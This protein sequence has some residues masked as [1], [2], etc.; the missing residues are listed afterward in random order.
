MSPG[1][2]K[3]RRN[4][5][6]GA[7]AGRPRR[8]ANGLPAAPGRLA[9]I[10]IGS[11]SIHMVVVERGGPGASSGYR[12]LARERDMVRLGKSALSEGA[13]SAR[14]MR[15]GL[16]AL[17]KMTTLAR[18]K[19]AGEI[20]A[21]ATSAVR[22]A[23][24]G[25]EFLAQ[26]RAL[27]GLDVRILSGEEEGE[28]IF[29]AVQHAID[30]SH[31]T[32]VL[33]DIGGGSTEWCVARKGELRSVQSVP[34]GS[35]RCA[36][37]LRGD[38]PAMRSIEKLRRAVRDGLA[39]LKVPKATARLIATS[40]TAACCGDLADLLAGREHGAMIGG[41]RELKLRDLANVVAG[42]Q[43]LTVKE[44]AALPP[45]GAPRSGSILAGAILL[46]ELAARAG[47]DRLFLCDRALREGLVL[48]ALGA[49]PPE[50]PVAGEVRRR[51]IVDLAGRAPGMLAHSQQVAHLAGRLFDITAAVHNLGERQ[52]EWL[53][54]AA[55]LHDIGYSIHFERH[56]KH[57]HYLI[58]TADLDGFDPR[59]IEVIAEVA[60]YHR[61]APP[62][63]RHVS[64]AALRPWQQ[65]AVEK[66]AALLRVANALDRTHATRVVELYA[67]L[68]GRREV[69]VEV[70]SPFDVEL[71]LQAARHRARLFETVFD[72]RLT[73]RQGLEKSPRQP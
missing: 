45:V 68:K 57:S 40:G 73:F 28:L 7:P 36:A 5:S 29:R 34:L 59:E 12:V 62:R 2:L 32:V 22:E 72:R 55:L 50:V 8:R 26:V 42:L 44:I 25:R 1:H 41:L 30:L 31:D 63:L 53:E 51:Q 49:P 3:V 35:L 10:D 11:N 20:V 16:E 70:M 18:L 15:K 54:F 37:G 43:T 58:T 60:R 46:Q 56:H 19:G 4:R 24:N 61:G 64:F 52:R 66:L 38:P 6:S 48:E 67:S 71:E 39:K 47:V 13:L 27:T 23:A 65:R 33:A 9:A 69:I 17:L 14:A 21:V